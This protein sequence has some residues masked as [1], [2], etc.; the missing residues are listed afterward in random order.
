MP[1]QSDDSVPPIPAPSCVL[2]PEDV[3]TIMSDIREIRIALTG[4]KLGQRG[5]FPR[6]DALE[7]SV[8][9]HDRKLL[10]WGAIL[11]AAGVVVV[12]LKDFYISKAK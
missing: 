12:F 8:E 3:I 11:S 9:R 7:T 5:V 1:S 6:L 2:A 4:N 10:I